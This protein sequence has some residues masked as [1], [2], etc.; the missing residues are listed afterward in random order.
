MLIWTIQSY[1]KIQNTNGYI[2]SHLSVCLV[3]TH[4]YYYCMSKV[5]ESC[6]DLNIACLEMNSTQF[7]VWAGWGHI[8]SNRSDH[9]YW[10]YR[11]RANA[12]VKR[13][14]QLMTRWC[15]TSS[16]SEHIA[17]PLTHAC[18]KALDRHQK[19]KFLLWKVFS[20]TIQEYLGYPKSKKLLDNE[21]A[22]LFAALKQSHR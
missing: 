12:S 9:I 8:S 19:L 20:N 16:F 11:N 15:Y 18:L 2:N 21:P 5:Q 3:T 1:F 4:L 7:T 13:H 14:G 10:S 22:F 17:G 6:S